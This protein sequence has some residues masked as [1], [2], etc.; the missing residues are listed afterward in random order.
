MNICIPVL[1]RYDLLDRLL[2]SLL[3][4]EVVPT[5]VCVID[6]GSNF[7]IKK[8]F[9]RLNIE[10]YRP[11][12]NIGVAKSWNWFIKNVPEIR[13]ITNDDVVFYPNTIGELIKAYKDNY[14]I[15]PNGM[16]GDISSFSCFM[17]SDKI[18]KD[19]GYFDE[20]ISP[21][22]AYFEDNDY[23]RRMLAKG[24]DIKQAKNAFVGHFISATLARY[25]VGELAQHHDKFRLA[26][27]NYTK[28]WGGLPGKE[29]FLTPFNK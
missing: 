4:S 20:D 2:E 22:Y 11:Q 7:S 17:L 5:K 18:V 9:A 24:Y 23:H 3:E 1:N 21:N 12:Q 25:S 19:V 14:L 16:A 26:R 10:T 27:K 15:F 28:K 29:T 8:E 13:L 6:N